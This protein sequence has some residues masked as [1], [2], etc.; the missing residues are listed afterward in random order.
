[1]LADLDDDPA[2]LPW[3][4]PLIE[5]MLDRGGRVTLLALTSH[6]LPVRLLDTLSTA[7]EVR[8]LYSGDEWQAALAETVRWADQLCAGIPASTYS[9]L[10]QN[11][12]SGRFHV[13]EGFAQALVKAGL[14]CGVG[15][16]L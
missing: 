16:C 1:L 8:T 6:P 4:M 7:L 5:P 3:L 14:L 10:Y 12:R 9:S 11:I 2:W 13:A 15:A